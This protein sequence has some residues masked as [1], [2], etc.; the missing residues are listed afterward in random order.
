MSYIKHLETRSKKTSFYKP[1]TYQDLSTTT[2]NHNTKAIVA[3]APNNIAKT[4]PETYNIEENIKVNA[5]V[6]KYKYLDPKNIC[7]PLKLGKGSILNTAKSSAMFEAI[8]KIS[9]FLATFDNK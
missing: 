1:I 9:G 7:N 5:K 4:N 6:A 8:L 3:R 2:K